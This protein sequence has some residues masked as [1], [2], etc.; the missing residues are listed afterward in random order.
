MFCIIFTRVNTKE[1]GDKMCVK[2]EMLLDQM[3]GLYAVGLIFLGEELYYAAA[4][5]NRDG[6]V[7]LI[8]SK[9]K[10]VSEICGGRGGVMAILESV[11]DSSIF[12]IEEFYPVFD[13]A[14]A[15]VA[16]IK[17]KEGEHGWHTEKRWVV[18]EIPYVHRIAKLREEDGDFIAAGRLC[19]KKSF[20][21]DWSEPGSMEI[22]R[23]D[24]DSG[25]FKPERVQDGIF[26]HH[27]M[28]VKKNQAG[29]D[30]LY[31]GGSEGAFLTVRKNGRW[32]TK[33]LLDAEVSDLICF[34]LDG[35]GNDEIAIIEGFHGN[36]VKIYKEKNAGDTKGG[37]EPVLE[38]PLDFGHVLWGGDFL[39]E[40]GMITGSRGGKKE[41]LLYRFAFND[42]K[43][44]CVSEKTIIDEGQAPAQICVNQTGERAEIVAANHGAAQLV[45]YAF[46]CPDR[47]TGA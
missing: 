3:P 44:L 20:S 5:E 35:D 45:R 8:H 47:G 40:P 26:K 21:D 14:T 10:K 46:A 37:Y 17:L 27:A 30:D 36:K 16:K 1:R 4:S 33:K 34:D 28:F 38:L 32:E 15:R 24:P 13:S 6:K 22:G 9:T 39:G 42:E 12:C 7:F 43:G 31:Y 18:A 41:L 29:Y 23:Y 25:I 19:E 2:K 11:E